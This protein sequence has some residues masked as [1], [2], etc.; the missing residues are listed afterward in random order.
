MREWID[1]RCPDVRI[2]I[3]GDQ[4]LYS[5]FI[6][7]YDSRRL[8]LYLMSFFGDWGFYLGFTFLPDCHQ[9]ALRWWPKPAVEQWAVARVVSCLLL[10][11]E[12]RINGIRDHFNICTP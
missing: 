8:V 11:L 12:P 7:T 4:A 2:L 9:N 10:L 3:S 5:D 1:S 6:T